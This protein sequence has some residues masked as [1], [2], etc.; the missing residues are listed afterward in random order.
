ML[1]LLT[2]A[3]PPGPAQ[4]EALRASTAIG[5]FQARSNNSVSD[6]KGQEMQMEA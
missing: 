5:S 3:L 6:I 1:Y 2:V 4:F